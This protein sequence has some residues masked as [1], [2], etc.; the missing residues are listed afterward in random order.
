MQKKKVSLEKRR[1]IRLKSVFPVTFRI[2][3]S[4]RDIPQEYQA[5]TCDISKGGLCIRVNELAKSDFDSLL[6]KD[7]KLSL[8]VNIPLN[9][10]PVEALGNVAWIECVK[11]RKP[12]IGKILIGVEYDRIDPAQKKRIS[13][14]ARRMKLLPW[15]S[16]SLISIL[17]LTSLGAH[18]RER[19]VRNENRRLVSRLHSA[20]ETRDNLQRNL[21]NIEHEETSLT[22]GLREKEEEIDS[23]KRD[24]KVSQ[25]TTNRLESRLR[26]GEIAEER[27][28]EALR[29]IKNM[30]RQLSLLEGEKKSLED[31]LNKVVASRIDLEQELKEEDSARRNLEKTTLDRMYHWLSIHQNPQTGLV[32]SFEGDRN[33]KSVAF[34]YDQSLV[35]QVYTLFS[36]YENARRIYDFYRFRADKVQ[37]GFANAYHVSTG[38]V[39]EYTVH[40]GPNIWLGLALLQYIHRTGDV[41]YLSFAEEIGDWVISMQN[42]S[43]GG[44]IKGGADFNWYSTEHNLDAYAFFVVLFEKT[45]KKKY[46]IAGERV[47]AWLKNNA[48][49]LGEQRMNRGRG[50]STIA[51]DTFAWAI[52]AI[53][54][55]LLNGTGMSPDGIMEFAEGNCRVETD[56]IR[57]DGE[58]VRVV[59][60]D[61]AKYTNLGRGGVISTE[62]T[63]QMIVSYAIMRDYYTEK[64]KSK[65][66]SNKVDFYRNELTKLIISSLS[67]TGQGDGCL[68]YATQ[69]NVDT[70]HGW[71]TPNGARTGSVSATSY[72]IFAMLEYNP[73]KLALSGQM[74]PGLTE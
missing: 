48:Y 28:K 54:P 43:V 32:A 21:N 71:R 29:D 65:I 67:K 49:N 44:G 6:S 42:K 17:I 13:S 50:D 3:K 27:L 39:S 2:L 24:L 18:L 16:I 68:P 58:K 36:D 22:T 26:Q 61:F 8:S 63:A 41:T 69:N 4:E 55:K 34:T 53:G 72:G 66:Y 1:Y 11:D 5:F 62:W 10:R 25:N 74:N 64:E 37:D 40:T 19:I 31:K 9:A 38:K 12:L 33:L 46:K 59:G 60:F 52:A 56:F 23:L 51:T 14:Y 47:F 73:L 20:L 70:G 7:V 57:P 35:S 30:E 45:G 15:I